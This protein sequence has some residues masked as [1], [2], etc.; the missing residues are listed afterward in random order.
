[1]VSHPLRFHFPLFPP[2]FTPFA[3]HFSLSNTVMDFA[4]PSVRVIVCFLATICT[5]VLFPACASLKTFEWQPCVSSRRALSLRRNISARDP[6]RPLK[7]I[8]QWRWRAMPAWMPLAQPSITHKMSFPS[9]HVHLHPRTTLS[10]CPRLCSPLMPPLAP[11]AAHDTSGWPLWRVGSQLG[12]TRS[13]VDWWKSSR[14]SRPA[15]MRLTLF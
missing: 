4:I 8:L 7:C 2:S 15:P 5:C 11:N 3:A 1:M 10:S 12:N 13:L 6:L 9:F 14:R